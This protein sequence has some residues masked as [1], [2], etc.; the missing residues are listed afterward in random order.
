MIFVINP[1]NPC[2]SVFSKE[3]MLEI[4]DFV[5]TS[6]IVLLADEIYEELAYEE[7]DTFY[8]FAEVAPDIP[9][10]KA[11]GLSKVFCVPGWRLGWAIVY[12]RDGALTEVLQGMV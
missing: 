2:G 10:I 8:H 5:R 9:I 7:N 3:H 1:S 11:G 12:N 4:A 6:Q